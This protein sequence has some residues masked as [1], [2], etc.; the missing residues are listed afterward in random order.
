MATSVFSDATDEFFQQYEAELTFED[1]LMGGVPKKPDVIEAWIRSK[2]GI[3]DEQEVRRMVVRTLQEQGV[4]LPDIPES[5][6]I[7]DLTYDQVKKA[8]ES[9]AG[10]QQTTGF[11][12]NGDGI[13]IESRQIK[14]AI[15]EAVN[16]GFAGLPKKDLWGPTKKSPKGFTAERVFPDPSEIVL[17]R[18][19]PDG[20]EQVIGH[21]KDQHGS[22][23]TL[24]YHEFALKPVISFTLKVLD[25]SIKPE[26][27]A[28]IWAIAELNGI[29]ALR[30]QGYGRFKVT[31]WNRLS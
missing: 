1:K 7:T 30:S 18:E 26:W 20:I 19:Q 3:E 24:G 2:A 27:W 11:K 22:R 14:A 4:E 28:R 21:I 25:D 29:G 5:A 9:I 10:Q 16:I 31:K 17:G 15:K 13:F 12:L 6:N 8:A 23:S